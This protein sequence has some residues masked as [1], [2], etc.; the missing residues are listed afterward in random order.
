MQLFIDSLFFQLSFA[1]AGVPLLL[2]TLEK[3]GRI[4]NVKTCV[5]IAQRITVSCNLRRMI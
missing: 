5:T 3:G 1:D 4:A 2:S